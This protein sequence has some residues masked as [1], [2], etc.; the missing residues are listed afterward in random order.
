M[1]GK[2]IRRDRR[3]RP[4]RNGQPGERRAGRLRAAPAWR[5]DSFTLGQLDRQAGRKVRA[6]RRHGCLRPGRGAGP[7][8]KLARETSPACASSAVAQTRLQSLSTKH[9]GQLTGEGARH[10]G[11]ISPIRPAVGMFGFCAQRM[12]SINIYLSTP[13]IAIHGASILLISAT[14]WGALA[15]RPEAQR[16][17]LSHG[18]QL[19]LWSKGNHMPDREAACSCGQLQVIVRGDPIRVAM[20]HCLECQRRTGSTFGV[21]AFYPREQVRLAKGLVKRYARRADSGRTVTF[22]FL[23]RM[24]GNGFLGTRAT[25]RVDRS[26]RRN[27][28]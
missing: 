7:V 10:W 4:W 28:R 12:T 14:I 15:G 11:S 19:W 2:A 24:R 18:C 1:A 16:T 6:A 3:R 9:F 22:N 23:S 13:L 20:C 27:V 17:V 5:I 25:P 8:D 21:Q 26:S